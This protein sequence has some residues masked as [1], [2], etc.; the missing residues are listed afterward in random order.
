MPSDE[1]LRVNLSRRMFIPKG[2]VPKP[3]FTSK[4]HPRDFLR[5]DRD[6]EVAAAAAARALLPKGRKHAR[7]FNRRLLTKDLDAPSKRDGS[8]RIHAR[9]FFNEDKATGGSGVAA[10]G[11]AQALAGHKHAGAA[12]A[13]AGAGAGAAGLAGAGG[14][15]AG[16]ANTTNAHGCPGN[17]TTS[18]G[19]GTGSTSAGFSEVDLNAAEK[20]TVTDSDV[21]DGNDTTGLDIQANDVG[22]FAK[23]QIGTVRWVSPPI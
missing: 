21:T 23:I 20:G 7:D 6:G 15:G 8:G 2:G 13:A 14:K 1:E 4:Q 5:A 22:Y 11:I 9:D 12:G 18:T 19:T 17:S 3:A 16:A 10:V